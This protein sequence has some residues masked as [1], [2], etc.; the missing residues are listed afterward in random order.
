MP[1]W[2]LDGTLEIARAWYD[3]QNV[4]M[5]G[6]AQSG[7]YYRVGL[8]KTA[9]RVTASVDAYRME[10]R[11]ATIVLPYGVPENQWGAAWAWPAPWLGSSY[12]LVDNS[13]L[14]VNRQGY[15]LRYFVDGGP[16]EIR[17]EF[18]DVQQIEPTTTVT[19]Q[20]TGFVG[21]YFPTELPADATLG[22]QLRYGVWMA[23]HPSFGDLTL[24]FIDDRLARPSSVP[25]DNVSLSVPQ[26]VLTYSR[27]FTPDLI[28]AIGTGRYTMTGTFAEPV[29]FHNQMLF[30]GAIVKETPQASLL[31]TFRYNGFY[32]I[33]SYPPMPIS[34]NFAG[35]Q[36]IIEQRY[37]L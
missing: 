20:E 32:G 27:H 28:W 11:Y 4:A 26:A 24:D 16:F 12:Q 5:P 36:V 7:G 2:N 35:S 34:P 8:L 31:A 22:R 3:A 10:P 33:P 25:L 29:N 18:T 30:T 6:T 37:Q 23:W 21:G 17:F 1:N 14:G 13:V 19:S 9:G 15:R